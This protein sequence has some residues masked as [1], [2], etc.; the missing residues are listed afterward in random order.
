M[1]RYNYL[2]VF[3]AVFI[4]VFSYVTRVLLLFTDSLDFSR[5]VLRKPNG[6]PWD[7]IESR[8]KSL[9]VGLQT[10]GAPWTKIEYNL[11]HAMFITLFSASELYH[12]TIREVC[13]IVKYLEPN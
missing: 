6:Q 12:S 7:R 10:G 13:Q 4:F 3:L 1:K 2:Y 11:L 9:S 8:L 5:R